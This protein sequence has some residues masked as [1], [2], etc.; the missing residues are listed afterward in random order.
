M[1]L[2]DMIEAV[3]GRTVDIGAAALTM[4]VEREEQLDFSHP[5]FQSG[6]AIAVREKDD[7]WEY[8]LRRLFSPAFLKVLGGLSLLLLLSGF[9]VWVF[10]RRNNP[11]NFGGGPVEGIWS[12]FWW[13][14]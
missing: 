7:G 8:A 5:Y 14:L 3:A 6:L 12:G 1:S 10:E 13:L 2:P 4:T 11:D 9:L